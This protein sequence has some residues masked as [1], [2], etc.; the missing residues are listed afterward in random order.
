[1]LLNSERLNSVSTSSTKTA[2]ALK[3]GDLHF[4]GLLMRV[5]TTGAAAEPPRSRIGPGPGPE[6]GQNANREAA[7][8]SWERVS[9]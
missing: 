9:E 2:L 8:K 7:V 3:A 4:T 1:M 6:S 5:F